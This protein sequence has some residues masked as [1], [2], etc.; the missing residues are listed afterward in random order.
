MSS[1]PLRIEL[2]TDRLDCDG[3]VQPCVNGTKDFSHPAFA[4]FAF[5]AVWTQMRRRSERG[6]NGILRQ[7][8]WVWEGMLSEKFRVR[9]LLK[10]QF[11]VTAQFGIGLRQQSR[12]IFG[13][14]FADRMVHLFEPPKAIA[15]HARVSGD[16][17]VGLLSS[18]SSQARAKLHSPLTVRSARCII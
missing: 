5:D 7:I 9:R 10:Q 2:F 6:D 18:W 8:R 17:S 4:E 15:S 13:S 14:S 3:P 12:P 16:F 1:Q 11:Q